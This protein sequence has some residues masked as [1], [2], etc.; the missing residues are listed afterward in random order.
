MSMIKCPECQKEISDTSTSCPNCGC[1][2]TSSANTLEQGTNVQ[3][4]IYKTAFIHSVMIVLE[5]F[6]LPIW[7]ILLYNNG[8]ILA[9]ANLYGETNSYMHSYMLGFLFSVL[10][11]IEIFWITHCRKT[12]SNLRLA[13][14]CRTI[15]LMWSSYAIIYCICYGWYVKE[16]YDIIHYSS[17]EYL[18]SY[19]IDIAAII[20]LIII[21]IFLFVKRADFKKYNIITIIWGIYALLV[22]VSIVCCSYSLSPYGTFFIS[23]ILT[24]PVSIIM[25]FLWGISSSK[26]KTIQ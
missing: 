22:V 19:I 1:P 12:K 2:I 17:R 7:T 10:I 11:F 9:F 3:T 13:D 4:E 23:A 18:F 20:V 15:F 16:Y 14:K 5:A 25:G 8:S 21:G 6:I 24:V 26:T